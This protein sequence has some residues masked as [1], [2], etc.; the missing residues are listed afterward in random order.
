MVLSILRAY[1]HQLKNG[2]NK[3]LTFFKDDGVILPS[4]SSDG[5]TIVFRRLFHL[6]TLS[7]KSRSKPKKLDLFHKVIDHQEP[8]KKSILTKTKDLDFSSSGLEIGF[9]ANNDIFVMDTILKEPV[10]VTESTA[11]ESNL[12]FGDKGKSLYYLK[13]DGIR[14]SLWKATK[15]DPS[16]YWWKSSEFEH[17]EI[18]QSSPT[19]SG[20]T[21]SPD[22]TQIAIATFD[23]R[24]IVVDSEGKDPKEI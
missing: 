4:I 9:I 18:Y 1:Q 12:L 24:L 8:I 20:F 21:L 22:E 14:T 7:T 17:T 5:S 6:Y 11:Y 15:K 2:K 3:Q 23:G 16:L 10:Q 13:D 19:I